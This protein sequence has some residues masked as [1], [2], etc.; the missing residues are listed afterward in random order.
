MP[1]FRKERAADRASQCESHA[2]NKRRSSDMLQR[3]SRGKYKEAP[4]C[5]HLPTDGTLEHVG[6][7]ALS[8][9]ANDV[10]ITFHHNR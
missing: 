1:G 3:Y 4:F 8:H 6:K 10:D 7:H 5:T 2:C 9:I